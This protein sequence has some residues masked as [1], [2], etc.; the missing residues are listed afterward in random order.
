MDA[1]I[2]T[3]DSIGADMIVAKAASAY[4]RGVKRDD[5]GFNWHRKAAID[6]WQATWDLCAQGHAKVEAHLEARRKVSPP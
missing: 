6:V 3:R 1:S 2:V 5:H 4:A